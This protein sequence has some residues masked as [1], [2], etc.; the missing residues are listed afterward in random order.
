[1][2]QT[3][4]NTHNLVLC[5]LFTALIAVGAFIRIP[6]PVVPFT[7]Q[8]LFTMMAGL[9]LGGK[10][11]ATSV[12]IYIVLGLAGLPV[13]TQGGGLGYVLKPT[14]GYIIGF[15]IGA[16]V[17]GTIA[18]AVPNPSI[19]RILTANFAGMAIVYAL[20]MVYF[21]AISHLYLGTDISLWNLFLY[22][23]LVCIPGDIFLAVVSALVFKRLKPVISKYRAI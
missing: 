18:N 23:F 16:Y 21:Y 2:S 14:F 3:K 12:I 10:L 20:G 5:A 9:M 8:L 22:C 4:S 7:L 1:M 6:I 17:T 13:F 19:K 15:A 11:G